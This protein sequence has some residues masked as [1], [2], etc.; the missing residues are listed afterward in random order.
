MNE[1]YLL[2]SP[3]YLE[4]SGLELGLDPIDY[5]ALNLPPYC[6]FRCPKCSTKVR[7]RKIKDPL[8]IDEV[9]KLLEQAKE[10]GAKVLTISGEGEPL[11]NKDFFIRLVKA[12]TRL[13]IH[14]L[15]ATNGSLLDS[16]MIDFLK[17]HRTSFTI[18]LDTL[19]PAKYELMAGIKNFFQQ[20][21]DNIEAV[22]K[23][24]RDNLRDEKGNMIFRVGIHSI[25]SPLNIAEI[26]QI[27]D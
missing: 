18:S 16:E 3:T 21:M 10:Y 15:F 25:L 9:E 20:V 2:G 1:K 19:D 23:A 8:C 13:D 22:R 26:G 4:F 17:A 14:T 12:A 24:F 11:F 7:G 5:L 27:T 6:N